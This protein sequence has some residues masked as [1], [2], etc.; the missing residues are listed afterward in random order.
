MDNH[1]APDGAGDHD[2]DLLQPIG[3]SKPSR[4]A[5]GAVLQ[6]VEGEGR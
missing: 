2:G 6:G 4:R 3:G 5:R 1:G